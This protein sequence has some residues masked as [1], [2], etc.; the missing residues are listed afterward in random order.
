MAEQNARSHR[1]DSHLTVYL[2]WP[3]LA[4]VTLAGILAVSVGGIALLVSRDWQ[5]ALTAAGVVFFA[6]LAV[7]TLGTFVYAAVDNGQ[8]LPGLVHR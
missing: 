6:T 1:G 4:G 7:A 2:L 3:A 8:E 5:G